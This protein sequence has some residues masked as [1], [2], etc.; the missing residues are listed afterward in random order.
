MGHGEAG[1]RYLG[2]RQPPRRPGHRLRRARRGPGPRLVQHDRRAV[3]PLQSADVGGHCDGREDGRTTGE[4]DVGGE[5]VHAREP[6]E[7]HRD[8]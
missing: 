6:A 7:G 8:D 3:L 4:H 5:G 1:V 2:Y